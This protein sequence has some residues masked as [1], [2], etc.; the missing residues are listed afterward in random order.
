[1]KALKERGSWSWEL[2][3]L[4]DEYVYALQQADQARRNDEQTVW[5]RHA[6][7]AAAIADQLAL[8][9]RGRKAS[10][11]PIRDETP[12]TFASL[13]ELAPRRKRHG[14]PAT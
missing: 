1:M 6:K 5:D 4:L 9:P 3:P 14:A 7:R 2:K 11:L 8:T 12:S 10:G 13:D